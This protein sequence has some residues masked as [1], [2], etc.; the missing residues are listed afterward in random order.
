[1][2]NIE[3]ALK[4]SNRYSWT[5]VSYLSSIERYVATGDASALEKVTAISGQGNYFGQHLAGALRRPDQWQDEDRRVLHVLAAGRFE[6]DVWRW[7][8]GQMQDEPEDQDW[9]SAVARELEVGH[10]QG[11][12]LAANAIKFLNTLQMRGKLNSA[13]RYILSLDE[14]SLREAAKDASEERNKL[15]LD[16][17]EL[18]KLLLA[19]RPRAMQVIADRLLLYG[20]G[21][22][23]V[24]VAE[25]LL[26]H[27]AGYEAAI[28]AA[29]EKTKDIEMRRGG[30]KLLYEHDP[31]RHAGLALDATR[32]AIDRGSPGMDLS[33]VVKWAAP[34]FGQQI[35]PDVIRR[36]QS[37]GSDAD[38]D[39]LAA[40]G[41]AFGKAATEGFVAVIDACGKKE[42]E[43]AKGKLDYSGRWKLRG[44]VRT[45]VAAVEQLIVRGDG[46]QDARI[47]AE[48]EGG[49]AGVDGESVIAFLTLAGKWDIHRVVEKVW[50]LLEHKSKPVREAA[51]RVLARAGDEAAGRAEALLAHKK[52]DVRMAAAYL[53]TAVNTPRALE[54][55]EAKL[56]TEENDDVRDQMLLGLEEAWARQGRKVSRKDVE[57]RIRRVAERIDEP[58][59]KWLKPE[60]LPP[61][62]WADGGK[63]SPK[64]VSYLLYRQSRAKEIRSDIEAKAMYNLIDRA[65]SGDFAKVLLE[66]FLSSKM[67]AADR[68]ALTAAC[69]LGDDR[70]VPILSSQVREWVD[71]NRGKL[72]EYAVQALALL[73]TD[74]ALL[75]VDAMAIRYRNKMKNV[76]K[77]AAEAFAGA[78]EALGIS[79]DELGD[80]VVPWLGFEP[81][82]PRIIESA[83]GRF[84]A[85]IGLDFKLTFKDLEKNKPVKALPKSCPAEILTELKEVSA[86]LREAVKAQLLRVE[87][88]LVRQRRW[89]A[90]RWKELFLSHPLLL[91]FAVRL[92][93]GHYDDS[94]KRLG[95]FRAL[96]DRT[97]TTEED[98][99]YALGESGQVGI[100]HPLELDEPARLAWQNHLA[101]YE[102]EPPFPQLER[103]VVRVAARDAERKTYKGL[104]G[105]SLNAM[106]FKGRAERLGW[107]RGS[108]CDGGGITSYVKNFPSAGADV[109]L[110]VEDFFVG[111]D[112]Y[113]DMK[114]GEV[115]FVRGGSVEFGSYVYDE[116]TGDEDARVLKFAEVPPIVF[117][118]AMG[119][120]ERIAGK[121]GEQEE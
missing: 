69:K 14:N 15:Y 81:G 16:F 118:E 56:D 7:L 61:L 95:V 90:R 75:T 34:R 51:A 29:C 104:A 98:E 76:G 66:S 106:T 47:Q 6:Q 42:G 37:D 107:H 100:V 114:L 88:L 67:D 17:A 80:R 83:N 13:A 112:M 63:V 43:L 30:A 110:G 5:T 117:S 113:S 38:E 55:L 93:W 27:D 120:L 52:G 41:K 12:R 50:G 103:Q 23:D 32:K 82:K 8:N 28:L 101:D 53:L 91:P 24:E 33:D 60:K 9:H 85:S 21:H 64:A 79:P 105:I 4:E 108:V 58:P 87:N 68:W 73:G 44:V 39:A 54:I 96:E 40:I 70:L 71:G 59:A 109:I 18:T 115:R 2:T 20:A 74:A 46:S 65:T 11:K 92:V 94:G 86:N 10:K 45:H 116:P 62:N 89:A 102:I 84:E 99:A 48:L 3:K 78:A 1:M 25:L 26:K 77:A 57:K 97:L 121:T 111:I 19:H 72:A 22:L 49:L 31:K 119:D 35:L 36:M